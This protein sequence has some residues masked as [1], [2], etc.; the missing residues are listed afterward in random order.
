MGKKYYAVKKGRE[1][2]IYETWKACKEQVDGFK[3][4]EYKSFS[5]LQDAKEY[6]NKNSKVDESPK[7][8]DG[9]I[10]YIDGSYDDNIKEYGS[11]IYIIEG[12]NEKLIKFKGND[13][14]FLDN[15]NV[16]GE[17]MACVYVLNYCKKSNIKDVSIC[18]DYEGIEKWANGTWQTKKTLTKLYKQFIDSV[19]DQLNINFVKVQAHSGDKGNNIADNLAKEALKG[20]NLLNLFE[21]YNLEQEE[22]NKSFTIKFF[23]KQNM[24]NLKE[25]LKEEKFDF[26]IIKD[27]PNNIEESFYVSSKVSK[28]NLR[29]NYYTNKTLTI[30]GKALDVFNSV[31]L[32]LSTYL[33]NYKELLK[34]NEEY[35]L[36]DVNDVYSELVN[37]IMPTSFNDFNQDIQNLLITAYG[38]IKMRS[39]D[40]IKDYSFYQIPIARCL[41]YFLKFI[42][43]SYGIR[44]QNKE[45][46]KAY[47]YC[48]NFGMF[49]R[50]D[51]LNKHI[52]HDQNCKS[53]INNQEVVNSLERCYNFYRKRHPFVHADITPSGTKIISDKSKVDEYILEGL[54]LIEDEY[55]KIKKYLN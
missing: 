11:G 21:N 17:L 47:I 7:F 24:R 51:K 44:I 1:I 10:A 37:N 26:T 5:N 45:D 42:F 32:F 12:E 38:C 19:K 25:Y 43:S 22:E 30:Q 33:E 41:E 20:N 14:R 48:N 16:A 23:E 8:I 28:S 36:Y 39:Y 9:L 40:F 3:G 46:R 50:D 13:E 29:F 4:A 35:L 55:K 27:L 15:N 52:L 53:K 2:G 49:K 18:Y 54:G 34:E 31:Q 6:L